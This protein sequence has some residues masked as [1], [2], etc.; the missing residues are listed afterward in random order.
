LYKSK[1]PVKWPVIILLFAGAFILSACGVSV[2]N[3]NWPGMTADEDNVV[4][5]AFGPGIV[6]VDLEEQEQLWVYRPQDANAN[7]QFFA[8]PSVDAGQLVFGDYG[9]SGGFIS[10]SVTVSVYALEELLGQNPVLA[11]SQSQVAQ[12]RI[13]AQPLQLEDKV[14]IGTAD[15]FVVALGNEN[16]TPLWDEPFEAGH[17]IWGHPIEADGVIYVPSLDKNVY[18]LD[19]E[20]GEE[21]WRSNVGGSVSDR[22]VMNGD[23]IYVGSFDN[24]VHALDKATGA[25]RWTAPA[26]APVW[27]APAYADGSVFFVDLNGNVFAIG[28][29]TGELR[30]EEDVAEFVIAATVVNDGVVYVATAGDP[31]I[32]PAERQGILIALSADTGEELWQKQTLAPIFTTPLIVGDSIVIA[33][34]D[35]TGQLTLEVIDLSDPERSWTFVP[36]VEDES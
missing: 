28:A 27:G 18:A 26:Q 31:D 17:S 11:W 19:A 25:S 3:S 5:V 36:Q 10:A 20:T 22:V 32:N 34:Q 6:A 29:D 4:Y 1:I 12:D 33:M 15:N 7:L 13:I 24:Q 14:I 21:I 30:W 23:L 35:E 9:A 16:G 8:P 2:A